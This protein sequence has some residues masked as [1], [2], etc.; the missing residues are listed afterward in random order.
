MAEAYFAAGSDLVETNSFG[1]NRFRLERS[2]LVGRVADVNRT[3]AELARSGAPDGCFVLGSVGPTGELLEPL[4]TQ[5]PDAFHDAY[6]EQAEAL[7]QGGVDGFCVETMLAIEEA[8]VAVRAAK[9]TTGLPVMATMTF[10]QGSRGLATQMGVTVTVA[11]EKLVGAGAD[12]VGANCGYG[13]PPVI[14]AVREMRP[15]TDRPIM[16]QP[17]AGAPVL[18]DGRT[19]FVETPEGVATS[20]REVVSAGAAIIGG[21]CGTGPDHIAAIARA[22]RGSG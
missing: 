5:T 16:A 9:E 19:V 4:G 18:R 13:A 22:L 3:A 21:C 2:G 1:G 7:A 14:Q 20:S 6:A 11:V 12:V 8:V 15:L 17:N 10:E